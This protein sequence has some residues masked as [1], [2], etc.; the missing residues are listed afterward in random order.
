MA[1]AISPD[2]R[3]LASAHQG[4]TVRIWDVATGEFL[5]ELDGHTDYVWSVAF[6]PDGRHFASGSSDYTVYV[7]DA[8]MGALLR[9]LDGHTACVRVVA[10]SADGHR[11]A[12][13]SD[14]CTVCVWDTATGVCV[15]KLR[16]DAS[17]RSVVFSLDSYYLTSASVSAS[18]SAFTSWNAIHVWDFA[19]G[20]H[21]IQK[22]LGYNPHT[23][24]ISF[25]ADGSVLSV[26]APRGPPVQL[27][28][29]SLEMIDNPHL[30]RFYLDKNSLC[31][32]HQGR[33]LHL[34]WLPDHFSPST[35]MMQHGNCICIGGS[36]GMIAVV[37]LNQFA[38]PNI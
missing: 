37:D 35:P 33:T 21:I 38:L 11:L 3:C 8:A 9:Q 19:K 4:G 23:P 18:T 25:S 6:S 2:G 10:F 22:R 15:Q 1:V 26:E 28:F 14:D 30:S 17:V 27:H 16:H 7:W 36:A 34:C 13:G 12:S 31:I 5:Q 32:R 24:N 20:S 29:P